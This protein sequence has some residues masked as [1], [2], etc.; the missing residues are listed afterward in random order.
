MNFKKEFDIILCNNVLE[1]IF[2]FK[3]AI[4]NIYGA[5]KSNGILILLVPGLYPLHDEPNDYWRFTEHSLRN[6]LQKFVK[7]KI[8][9]K[10]IRRYPFVYYVEATK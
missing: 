10:G 2:D 8:E 9:H 6:L 7:I 1:H 3:K 5:L 4:E